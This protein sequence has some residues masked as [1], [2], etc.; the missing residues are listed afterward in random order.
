MSVNSYHTGYDC[1]TWTTNKPKM[2]LQPSFNCKRI[3]G[4]FRA[5]ETCQVAANVVLFLLNK[6]KK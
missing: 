6:S 4:V 2:R 3:F 5:K 1:N